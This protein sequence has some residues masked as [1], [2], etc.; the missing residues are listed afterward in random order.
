[1]TARIL[2]V[3]DEPDAKELFRQ[4]FRREIRQGVCV[5]DFAHSGYEALEFLNGEDA[6]QVILVL[7]DINMPGMTGIELLNEIKVKWPEIPVFMVTAYADRS[8]EER[9]R[10]IG[11]SAF[12]A[13][14]VDFD[15]LRSHLGE[16]LSGQAL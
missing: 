10:E 8:T 7:S 15:L 4:Q 5:F 13:K 14:P 6:P 3:D 11:A 1:M 16:V 9:T 2:M 12:L